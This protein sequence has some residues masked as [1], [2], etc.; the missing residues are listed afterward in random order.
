MN[1]DSF[2]IK[3]RRIDPKKKKSTISQKSA[4]SLRTSA[5][6][7]K[8]PAKARLADQKSDFRKDKD[9][10]YIEEESSPG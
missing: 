7:P 2:V 10:T 8:P 1:D 3:K 4:A 6:A 5:P 9:E